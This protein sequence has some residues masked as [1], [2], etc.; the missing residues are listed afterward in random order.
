MVPTQDSPVQERKRTKLPSQV[1][2]SKLQILIVLVV[3]ILFIFYVQ[4]N[5]MFQDFFDTYNNCIIFK[6]FTN[7]YESILY[8]ID[9]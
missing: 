2:L 1:C 4:K 8:I 3:F 5:E 7:I 6:I 9:N